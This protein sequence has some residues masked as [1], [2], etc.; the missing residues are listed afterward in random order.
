MALSQAWLNANHNKPQEKVLEKA[1][2]DGLSVRVSVKGKITFQLRFR[3]AGKSQRCDL[4]VYP[5]IGL[6]DARKEAIRFK[7]DVAAG[8]DPRIMKKIEKLQTEQSFDVNNFESVFRRWFHSAK[9][10]HTSAWEIEKTFN[11]HIKPVFGPL[12][13]QSIDLF[14][15]MEFFERHAKERPMITIR[16]LTMCKL[17]Y[18]WAIKR[19]I[20]ESN[21]L[22]EISIVDD[23]KIRRET[24]KRILSAD[25]IT[26]FYEALELSQVWPKNQILMELCLFYGCRV[27]EL[28][29]A[30]RS[31]FDFEEKI[32]T[33]P[34]EN[35]KTGQEVKEPILRPIIDEVVPLLKKLMRMSNGRY[36]FPHRHEDRP[37]SDR[38]HIKIPG[39]LNEWI[40]TNHHI[41]LEPWS[42]HDLRRT[43]RSNWASITT[44]E[45][46]P[47]LMLGHKLKG[48]H[49][50]YNKYKYLPEMTEIY[51]AWWERL[52]RLRYPS[53]YTNVV[54]MKRDKA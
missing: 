41:Q 4:G 17:M 19:R 6:A 2:R 5:L 31:H 22:T 7:A 36:L 9:K 29:L 21:P 42:T 28:R 30:E 39:Q 20:V 12:P 46:V 32:W 14:M 8:R 52:Q 35:H 38:S 25:E 53:L 50:I 34:W 26:Y 16:M 51:K 11:L 33:V 24:G 37:V 3:F 15:W 43:A 27:S 47:E 48:V 18:R 10:E 13:P 23:L 49:H 1:D 45:T 40:K 44:S 54:E